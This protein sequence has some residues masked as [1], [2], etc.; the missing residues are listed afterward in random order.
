MASFKLYIHVI[1]H[2]VDMFNS[3]IDEIKVVISIGDYN[4][5]SL[6]IYVYN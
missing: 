2:V 5:D 1:E 4:I 6:I 3:E